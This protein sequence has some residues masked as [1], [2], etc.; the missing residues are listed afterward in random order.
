MSPAAYQA[1][2]THSDLVARLRDWKTMGNAALELERLPAA[3]AAALATA[4]FT[5]GSIQNDRAIN[6]VASVV[7]KRIR[8][9]GMVDAMRVLN[10]TLRADSR[11]MF[12]AKLKAAIAMVHFGTPADLQGILR[13]LVSDT[14][15]SDAQVGLLIDHLASKP[16]LLQQP[17]TLDTLVASLNDRTSGAK[18]LVATVQ[19]LA[20]IPHPKARDA[21]GENRVTSGAVFRDATLHSVLDALGAHRPP[22]TALTIHNLRQVVKDADAGS[23]E[24]AKALLKKAGVKP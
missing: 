14:F 13:L 23:A 4:V 19:A 18:K 9:P 20:R 24:R 16:A 11:A 21:I 7:A 12:E 6:L 2:V 10:Q 5:D 8:E 22:F 1:S 3:Q 17:V 15:G